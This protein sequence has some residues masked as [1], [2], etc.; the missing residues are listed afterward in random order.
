MPRPAEDKKAS[1]KKAAAAPEK[2]EKKEKKPPSSKS[3]KPGADGGGKAGKGGRAT[4]PA[5]PPAPRR[6]PPRAAPGAPPPSD[7]YLAGVDLPSSSDSESDASS[8]DG[9]RRPLF[10]D[11]EAPA[12][13]VARGA[14][15]KESRKLALR[16][17]KALEAQ[18]AAKA[19]ALRDD[20]SAFDV[21]FERQGD[22]DGA[23][24]LSA[25]D[26][27]VHSLTIRAKGKVLL[28][29]TTCT[30]A[31]GR[32][33]G[34][35]GP[36]GMGKSTLL[37]M[38]A[39]RQIPVPENLDVLLVEQEVVGGDESALASVVAADA[40]LMALRAEE[41]EINARLAAVDL[42]GEGAD[43]DADGAAAAPPA[44]SDEEGELGAR[45]NEVYD[46][47]AILGGAS[48]EARAAKILHGL[49][50]D[51]PMRRR[52]TRL[53]SGGW[54][55]RISLARALYLQ[56]ALLLLD[57][58]RGGVCVWGWVVGAFVWARSEL[59]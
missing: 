7:D 42:D 26:V 19:A 18:A 36:N 43:A 25:T 30:I 32:R 57:E 33:Y 4:A 47:I 55:M 14:S 6:P 31:A 58:V 44:D 51:E 11:G 21:A 29:N 16:D 56:P 40:E 28:E 1:K 24:T 52:A 2:E 37:R 50:F 23:A 39:R 46:R 8:S 35:V 48:A 54:R 3:A 41:A 59:Q 13:A 27:V 9:R 17:R 5:P 49:G 38:I 34:L 22:G 15:A 20:D 53:F 12:A 10:A 45:L